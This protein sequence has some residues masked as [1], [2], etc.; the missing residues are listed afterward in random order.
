MHSSRSKISR[1]NLVK[2]RCAEGFNS[3]VKGLMKHKNGLFDP[4]PAVGRSY[5]SWGPERQLSN[6]SKITNSSTVTINAT[7][8]YALAK[9]RVTIKEMD[10]FNVIKTLA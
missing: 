2:Q 8:Y 3:G 6:I 10:T 5:C 7:F 1:K 4:D 9:Y